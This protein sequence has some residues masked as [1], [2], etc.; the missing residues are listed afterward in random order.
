MAHTARETPRAFLQTSAKGS[1]RYGARSR[2]FVRRLKR[3]RNR[4]GKCLLGDRDYAGRAVPL[5]QH[6]NL[7]FPGR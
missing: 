5:Q 3:A 2:N 6:A 4:V 7:A 1:D